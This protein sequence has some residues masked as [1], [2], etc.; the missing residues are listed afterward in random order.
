[1]NGQTRAA[2]NYQDL[3]PIKK[4]HILEDYRGYKKILFMRPFSNVYIG[5]L[6]DDFFGFEVREE[7][8]LKRWL[9]EAKEAVDHYLDKIF[10]H[11]PSDEYDIFSRKYKLQINA[12]DMKKENLK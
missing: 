3:N 12:L 11:V 10:F 2:P 6:D 9:M 7:D 4:I 5:Y 1:M 8:G